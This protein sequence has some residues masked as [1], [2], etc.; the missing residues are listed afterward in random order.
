MGC[1]GGCFFAFHVINFTIYLPHNQRM[2]QYC[3]AFS[4]ALREFISRYSCI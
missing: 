4:E 1:G 2:L 3:T